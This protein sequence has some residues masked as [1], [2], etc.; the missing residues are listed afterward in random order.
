MRAPCVG[1]GPVTVTPLRILSHVLGSGIHRNLQKSTGILAKA[2]T[3]SV[4]RLLTQRPFRTFSEMHH[5]PF[6][7]LCL[8]SLYQSLLG[9]HIG[10]D[11]HHHLALPK[12]HWRRTSIETNTQTSCHDQITTKKH[13]PNTQHKGCTQLDGPKKN[14]F[15][16]H[17]LALWRLCASRISKTNCSWIL[18]IYRKMC[19]IL[20]TSWMHHPPNQHHVLS[21]FRPASVMTKICPPGT[22]TSALAKP[23]WW[24][25]DLDLQS[26][27]WEKKSQAQVRC[28]RSIPKKILIVE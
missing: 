23:N 28:K 6:F 13:K 26:S 1:C 17:Q 5:H 25:I 16:Q 22:W 2:V 8:A 10:Q 12:R 3:S 18:G 27:Y 15:Y 24:K 7:R 21:K 9:L 14:T 4:T 19:H 20:C 11:H